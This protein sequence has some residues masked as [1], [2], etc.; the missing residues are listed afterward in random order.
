MLNMKD[1]YTVKDF[2]KLNSN[3]Q[4]LD[5]LNQTHLIVC[6]NSQQAHWFSN[7]YVQK[8]SKK[9]QSFLS[10]QVLSFSKW[11]ESSYQNMANCSKKILSHNEQILLWH[12]AI[13]QIDHQN[14]LSM[15]WQLARTYHHQRQHEVQFSHTKHSDI[16]LIQ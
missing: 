5:D 11:L 3:C 13:C 15:L 7:L 14:N 10:P 6:A 8:K 2:L 16:Q 9:A 1:I 4:E 12:H